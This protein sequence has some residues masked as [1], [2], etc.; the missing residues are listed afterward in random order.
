[1]RAQQTGITMIELMIVVAIIAIVAA[2]AY[3]SYQDHVAAARRAEAQAA[4]L[5]VVDLQEKHYIQNNQYSGSF[6]TGAGDIDFPT[7]T[8]AGHWTLTMGGGG[9]TFTVT[10][11]TASGDTECASIS[12]DN[13]GTKS[14]SPA[15]SECW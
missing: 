9:A 7:T 3:P 8:E 2:V 14:N 6:G 4:L 12:I 10:A 1:M 5:R 13:T 15:A 11:N